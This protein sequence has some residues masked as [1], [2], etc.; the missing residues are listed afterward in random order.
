MLELKNSK[1]QKDTK[2]KGK[3]YHETTWS[4]NV[5]ARMRLPEPDHRFGG[6]PPGFTHSYTCKNLKM[7]PVN[8]IIACQSTNSLKE[9]DLSHVQVPYMLLTLGILARNTWNHS[10]R[11]NYY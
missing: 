3:T 2:P 8:T 5:Q 6:L 7:L 4:Q 9:S 1:D 11:M 10:V